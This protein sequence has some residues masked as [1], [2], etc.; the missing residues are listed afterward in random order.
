MRGYF[1]RELSLSPVT[2]YGTYTSDIYTE[3]EGTELLRQRIGK[4]VQTIP[5]C[6]ALGI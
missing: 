4:R 6:K 2:K 1:Q 3:P 5:Q